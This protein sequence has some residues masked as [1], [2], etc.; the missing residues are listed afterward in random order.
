MFYVK[1]LAQAAARRLTGVT[2]QD[3]TAEYRSVNPLL[4]VVLLTAMV[5]TAVAWRVRD[6]LQVPVVY[7]SHDRAEVRAIGAWILTLDR[8]RVIAS[9]PAAGF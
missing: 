8:G 6:D 9:E 4:G 3:F 2:P 5:L 1:P 7:V